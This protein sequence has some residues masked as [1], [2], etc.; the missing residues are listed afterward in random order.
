VETG[1]HHLTQMFS[2]SKF[3]LRSQTPKK[4]FSSVTPLFQVESL[5]LTQQLTVRD[6]LNQAMEEEM[7]A[8]EN[9]NHPIHA[10]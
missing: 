8:D 7:K 1:S 3:L 2:R 9:V 5:S 10:C 6:A 4:Y